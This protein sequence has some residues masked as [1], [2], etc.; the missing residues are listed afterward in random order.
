MSDRQLAEDRVHD[1][2]AFEDALRNLYFRQCPGASERDW[3][4]DRE[5]IIRESRVALTVDAAQRDPVTA[6]V[7]VEDE[8]CALTAT[9]RYRRF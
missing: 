8:A 5:E 6:G 3:E 9:N 1:A 4:R 2:A 7:T